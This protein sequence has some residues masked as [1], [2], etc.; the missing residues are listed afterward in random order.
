MFC[1]SPVIKICNLKN[2]FFLFRQLFYLLFFSYFY[3]TFA[4]SRFRKIVQNILEANRKSQ[5]TAP[6]PSNFPRFTWAAIVVCMFCG[7]LENVLYD[8]QSLK[9]AG[10][11]LLIAYSLNINFLILI[12]GIINILKRKSQQIPPWSSTSQQ[13]F[14][15]G[16]LSHITQL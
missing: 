15:S 5:I 4:T 6:F 8:L 16:H 13:I 9:K 2:F 11:I 10:K 7:I 3:Q 12:S 14:T 1:V